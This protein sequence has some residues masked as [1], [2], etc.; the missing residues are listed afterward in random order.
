[1]HRDLIA[2]TLELSSQ[3]VEVYCHTS[4]LPRATQSRRISRLR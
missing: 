1:M 2:G 3:Q 4:W